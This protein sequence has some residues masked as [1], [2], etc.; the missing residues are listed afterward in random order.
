[1]RWPGDATIEL[2]RITL[3]DL[4]GEGG[5]AKVFACSV[6]GGD[7]RNWLFKRYDDNRPDATKLVELVEW[8][9]SLSYDDR[10]HI[11]KACS[12][13]AC[14]VIDPRDRVK[15]IGVLLPRATDGFYLP[16]TESRE[17]RL[18]EF[19]YI[20][21]ADRSAKIGITIPSGSD[22]LEIIEDLAKSLDIMHRHGIVHGDISMKNVLWS[23][24]P[25]RSYLLDCDGVSLNGSNAG[26]PTVTTPHWTDPRILDNTI[27]SPDTNS[28]LW[29]LAAAF[30]R[31][32]F[33]TRGEDL[34][35][36]DLDSLPPSPQMSAGLRG[37]LAN[38]FNAPVPYPTGEDW[39]RQVERLRSGRIPKPVP[40]FSRP[41]VEQ[42]PA[43]A[44]GPGGLSSHEPLS[45]VPPPEKATGSW[46]I[47]A[48]AA[49]LVAIVGATAI[50]SLSNPGGDTGSIVAIGTVEPEPR[51]PPAATSEPEPTTAT[52]LLL[53]EPTPTPEPP[54]SLAA[55]R[56]AASRQRTVEIFG[57]R[58]VETIDATL[59][60]DNILLL[61]DRPTVPT[62][63]IEVGP[64]SAGRWF[65]YTTGSA[66]TTARSR[67]TTFSLS[68]ESAFVDDAAIVITPDGEESITWIQGV[69]SDRLI[70]ET[71]AFLPRGTVAYTGAGD[72]LGPIIRIGGEEA[73]IT[74]VNPQQSSASTRGCGSVSSS[75]LGSENW[76]KVSASSTRS[77]LGLQRLSDAFASQDW[78]AARNIDVDRRNDSDQ[79]LNEGWGMLRR[80]VLLPFRSTSS[81]DRTTWVVGI[82]GHE[83]LDGREVSTLFCGTWTFDEGSGTVQ[84]DASGSRGINT[85]KDNPISGWTPFESLLK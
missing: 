19:Q 76:S 43:P 49:V 35:G 63:W 26:F 22:T 12:W 52:T 70:V 9:K 77:L 23:A 82:M 44:S 40:T 57:C 36:L 85:L 73:I 37:L 1:M 66:A 68:A 17:E 7:D 50:I 34:D 74:E 58:H 6:A 32:Y 28:D 64:S 4:L 80:S 5:Q 81:G 83:V 61:H 78:N 30:Y 72:L 71:D 10:I 65:E 69:E 84:Q 75:A 13:P 20:I 24:S 16:K 51:D 38:T 41:T 55:A 29:A 46:A 3:G 67:K 31:T 47:R 79:R 39:R 59:L 15:A 33:R 27:A 56:A 53:A 8:P 21:L 14:V 18:R 62:W 2:S 42:P 54:D 48:V 45:P 25:P 60:A 11:E